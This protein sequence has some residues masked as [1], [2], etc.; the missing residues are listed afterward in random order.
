MKRL[1]H[2]RLRCWVDKNFHAFNSSNATQPRSFSLSSVNFPNR[3]FEVHPSLPRHSV[4]RV[5]ITNLTQPLHA[6]FTKESLECLGGCVCFTF[7]SDL[8]TLD[9]PTFINHT[10]F[11]IIIKIFFCLNKYT[12]KILVKLLQSQFG[13]LNVWNAIIKFL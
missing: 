2:C 13:H 10:L 6:T 8:C 9:E 4:W 11:Y 5:W 7:F 1:F 12:Y 3:L